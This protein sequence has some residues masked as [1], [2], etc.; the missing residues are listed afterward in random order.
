MWSAP[1]GGARIL[2]PRVAGLDMWETTYMHALQGEHA[3]VNWARG[4]SL[5]PFLDHLPGAMQPAFL[6]AYAEALAPHY[7]RRADGS[8]ML[9][10]RRLFM[11]AW[12]A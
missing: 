11:L 12:K 5:R 6:D 2:R 8:T 9:P 4:T 1:E 3:A 7:P 10:F